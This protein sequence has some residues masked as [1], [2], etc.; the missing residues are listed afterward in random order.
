MSDS[1]K[2]LDEALKLI[3][4]LQKE[5]CELKTKLKTY[6]NRKSNN[7]YYHRN[8]AE[9]NRRRRERYQQKVATNNS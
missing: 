6:T 2:S 5:N 4:T 1:I 8:S 3:D 7:D 9:I